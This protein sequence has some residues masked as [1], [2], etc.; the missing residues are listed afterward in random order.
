MGGGRSRSRRALVGAGVA[1]LVVLVALLLIAQARPKRA[2]GSLPQEVYVWQRAWGPPV[3]AALARMT[4]ASGFTVLA[5][6]VSWQGRRPRV[7]R[8][9]PDYAALRATHRP[10]GLALRVGAYGGPFDAAAPATRLL[11]KLAGEV[12]RAARAGGLT[13]VEL[14]LDFDCAT[15][16]LDGYR[17]W[18]E[19]LREV[20][21]ETPV[22]I[23]ALPTWLRSPDFPSLVRAAPGYVLQVHSLHPPA[24]PEAHPSLCDPEEARAWVEAAGRVGVPFRVALPT[25]GYLAAFTPSAKLL[26]I[27]AEGPSRDWPADTRLRA[28]RSDAAAMAELVRGWRRDRPAALR[29]VI[30]YRLP[31]E[32]DRLNWSAEAFAAVMRGQAPREALRVSATHPS[33]ELVEVWVEN[34]GAVDTPPLAEVEITWKEGSELVGVDGLRG[35]VATPAGARGFRFSAPERDEGAV[36]APGER[37]QIGWLR[38]EKRAEVQVHVRK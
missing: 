36:L 8:L 33:P 11:T 12:L 14:Q 4:A 6:E 30:W 24:S 37:W 26:A 18:V 16:K 3:A 5:A 28:V 1:A 23:T 21:G 34:A 22:T 35:Y 9:R 27:S 31:V 10:I 19:A 32:G 25:Y 38:F 7:T 29:G 2:S 17:Q 15:S 20:A 13:A